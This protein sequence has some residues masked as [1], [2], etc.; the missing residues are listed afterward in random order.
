MQF[1]VKSIPTSCDPTDAYRSKERLLHVQNLPPLATTN[2]TSDMLDATAF[3][4]P[5]DTVHLRRLNL[6]FIFILDAD[7]ESSQRYRGF[8]V[9][10]KGSEMS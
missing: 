2:R 4:L 7:L 8:I 3:P 6:S 5:G 9:L 1:A 10:Q